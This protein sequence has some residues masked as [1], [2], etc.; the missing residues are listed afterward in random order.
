MKRIEIRKLPATD[1]Q[2]YLVEEFGGEV[3][4]DGLVHGEGWLARFIQGEPIQMRLTTV[5]VLFVEFEGEREAEACAFLSQ[6]AMR[7]GG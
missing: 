6:K 5:P 7:G 4:G 2:R 3:A 1:M